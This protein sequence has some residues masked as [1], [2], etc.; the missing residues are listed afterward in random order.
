MVV[1]VVAVVVAVVAVVLVVNPEIPEPCQMEEI[2][3]EVE[4]QSVHH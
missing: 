2:V 3:S 4:C 1:V